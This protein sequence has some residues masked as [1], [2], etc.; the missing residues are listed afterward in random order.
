[1]TRRIHRFGIQG[2]Q[3]RFLA[4]G[5]YPQASVRRRV[6]VTIN[7]RVIIEMIPNDSVEP[8]NPRRARAGRS[9]P[10]P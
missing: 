3:G 2:V 9:D 8:I 6:V 5:A 1:V 4:G 10:I 7:I